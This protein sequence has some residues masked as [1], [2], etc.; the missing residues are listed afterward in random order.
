MQNLIHSNL[1]NT[2]TV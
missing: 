1:S 2:H